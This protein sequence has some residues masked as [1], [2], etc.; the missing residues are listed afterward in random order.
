VF[1]KEKWSEKWSEISERQ[2]E[3]PRLIKANPKLT[4]NEL[5]E[6]IKINQSA[7]QKH[8]KQLKQKGLL[9]RIGPAKG[10]YWEVKD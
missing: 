3:I 2:T 6:N 4:R 10:G 9:K 5:S 7:I 1:E 8:L